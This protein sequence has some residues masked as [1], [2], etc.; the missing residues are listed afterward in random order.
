MA[1]TFHPFP[2][3]P[4]ELRLVIWE[5]SISPRTINFRTCAFRCGGD[6][7]EQRVEVSIPTPKPNIS[8]WTFTS[9]P[10]PPPILHTCRESRNIGLHFQ[11]G[12]QKAFS[13]WCLPYFDGSWNNRYLWVHFELDIFDF[14]A[15]L[16]SPIIRIA[17]KDRSKIK[18]LRFELH[19]T[20]CIFWNKREAQLESWRVY[21]GVE[22][23]GLYGQS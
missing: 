6:D 15:D 12:Y 19:G 21:G 23:Y 7:Q 9:T 8:F 1:T 22:D 4:L 11:G 14:G 16:D 2:R 3:L 10:P 5:A 20:D 13:T 18:Q 17:N